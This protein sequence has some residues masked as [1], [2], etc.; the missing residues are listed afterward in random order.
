MRVIKNGLGWDIA[1][2]L[3][4][5][6]KQTAAMV[7]ARI[8]HA[9]HALVRGAVDTSMRTGIEK[10]VASPMASVTKMP[11]KSEMQLVESSRGLL[12]LSLHAKAK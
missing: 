8:Q 12:A 2:D 1:L 4:F 5:T 3:V 9:I 7:G 6:E 10:I 11:T